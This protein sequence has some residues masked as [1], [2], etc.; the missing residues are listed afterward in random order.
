VSPDAQAFDAERA[1]ENKKVPL[2][3][4]DQIAMSVIVSVVPPFVHEGV[5][6]KD[7]IPDVAEPNVALALVVEPAEIEVWPLDPG[8]AVCNST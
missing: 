1:Q 7:T 3:A 6:V 5:V 8:G 2:V 4:A